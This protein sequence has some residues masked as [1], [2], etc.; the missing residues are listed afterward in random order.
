MYDVWCRDVVALYHLSCV[1]F[2]E[3]FG[4][5]CVGVRRTLVDAGVILDQVVMQ[6]LW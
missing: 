4:V 1:W 6:Q 5:G 3:V 2:S